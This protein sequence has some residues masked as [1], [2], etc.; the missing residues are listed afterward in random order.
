MHHAEDPQHY[1]EVLRERGGR[2]CEKSPLHGVSAGGDT[3]M[4]QDEAF[5]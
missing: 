3:I 5:V 1:S 4:L 2:V